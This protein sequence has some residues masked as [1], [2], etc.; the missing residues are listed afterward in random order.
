MPLPLIGFSFTVPMVLNNSTLVVLPE[1]A[2]VAISFDLAIREYLPD[3]QHHGIAFVVR[4]YDSILSP[5][6]QINNRK[7]RILSSE[8]LQQRVVQLLVHGTLV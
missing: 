4:F 1:N 5:E 7:R 6:L 8:F 2:A 3:E